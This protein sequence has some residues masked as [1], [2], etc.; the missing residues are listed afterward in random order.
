MNEYISFSTISFTSPI[1]RLNRESVQ[2]LGD[3]S[4]DN[5]RLSATTNRLFGITPRIQPHREEYRFIPRT[6]CNGFDSS[7]QFLGKCPR[8]VALNNLKLVG[9]ILTFR[10]TGLRHPQ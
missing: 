5:R 2:Q 7:I 1:A 8:H 3:E 4:D 10:V 6:A 9:D